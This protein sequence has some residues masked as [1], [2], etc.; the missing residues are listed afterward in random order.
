MRPRTAETIEPREASA[1]SAFAHAR[2][3][4]PAGTAR[5]GLTGEL[6]LVTAARAGAAIRRA[7][8]ESRLL[9]C[10]LR[11]L[12]FID[13]TGLQVLLDAAA[14]A[15]RTGSRL[16]VANSPPSLPCMLRLLELDHALEVPATPLRTPPVQ[17]CATF[18]RHV[19]LRSRPSG[20]GIRAEAE[21]QQA[22]VVGGGV[23]FEQGCGKRLDE[24]RRRGA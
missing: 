20:S 18:R 11:D 6:D 24:L 15:K 21:A 7:Q 9:I 17:R 10:D 14:H 22:D 4:A 3:P 23:P 13:L 19:S 2:L 16:I 8:D 12:R 5:L 1:D